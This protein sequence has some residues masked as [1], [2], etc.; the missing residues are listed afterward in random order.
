MVRGEKGELIRAAALLV[1]AVHCIMYIMCC[2]WMLIWWGGMASV[3]ALAH[4]ETMEAFAEC[5]PKG[6]V[7]FISG[8]NISLLSPPPPPSR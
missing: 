1:T 8:A 4:M 5:F 3:G 7:K 6:V 2:K